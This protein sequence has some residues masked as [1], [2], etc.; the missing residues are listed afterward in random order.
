MCKARIALGPMD[1]LPGKFLFFYIHGSWSEHACASPAGWFP[2]WS[3]PTCI[4]HIFENFR[5]IG[6]DRESPKDDCWLRTQSCDHYINYDLSS[7]SDIFKY[8]FFF[9]EAYRTIRNAACG[10]DPRFCTSAWLGIHRDARLNISRALGLFPCM[11]GFQPYALS[12]P[13]STSPF[14]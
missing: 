5:E 1:N 3:L 13:L 8:P 11:H 14:R 6:G 10:D 12:R 9:S 4:L 7:P 2:G